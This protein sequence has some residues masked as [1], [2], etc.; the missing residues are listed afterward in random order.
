MGDRIPPVLRYGHVEL[1]VVRL[2]ADELHKLNNEKPGSGDA[3]SGYH[4]TQDTTIAV[5]NSNDI[6]P[7]RAWSVL[8]H[9]FF[10][11]AEDQAGLELKETLIDW[12]AWSML[13]MLLSNPELQ[14]LMLAD[15]GGDE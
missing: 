6:R 1:R 14:G 8:L 12:A 10:H 2:S 3:I 9:E 13:N 7:V 15:L 5:A 4:D 11:E